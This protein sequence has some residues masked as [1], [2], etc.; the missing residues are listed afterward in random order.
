MNRRIT[1]TTSP[2]GVLRLVEEHGATFNYVNAATAF[3]R[4]AKV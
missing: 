4:L 1:S 2:E 3:H